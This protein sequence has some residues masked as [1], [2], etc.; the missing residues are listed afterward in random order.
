M[1]NLRPYQPTN[2]GFSIHQQSLDYLTSLQQ[3]THAHLNPCLA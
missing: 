2:S 3:V 1:Q